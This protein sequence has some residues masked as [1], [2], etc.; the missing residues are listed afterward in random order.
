MTLTRHAVALISGGLDST[1]AAQLM[2]EQ[3]IQLHGIYFSMLWG[4]C[5]KDKALAAA[6]TLGIPLMVYKV[7]EDYIQLI[8][9]PKYGYGSQMNPCIDCRSYMF[10]LARRY[11][12]EL[13]ASFVVTGEVLGQRPMSQMRRSLDIIEA[14]SGLEGRLLRPLSA[15]LLEPTLP[16]VLGIV[17]RDKLLAINGR[18]RREQVAQVTQR[19]VS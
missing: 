15:Q 1:L 5:D 18:S 17:D 19:G 7:Q 4:C 13:G 10:T 6:D 3:G 14:E 16:E 12:D 2:L 9:R 8:K 11:M